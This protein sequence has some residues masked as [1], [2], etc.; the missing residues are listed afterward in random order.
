MEEVFI[1]YARTDIA[2]TRRLHDALEERGRQA[3]VDWEGIP[4]IDQWLAKIRSAIDEADAFVFVISPD[5]VASEVCGIE[6][7]H[8]IR[9]HKRLIPVVYREVEASTVR[10]ELAELNYIFA[11]DVDAFDTACERLITALDTDLKWVQAHTR[12]LVR[13]AEWDRAQRDASYTLRGRD[14]DDF[15]EW[16]AQSPDKEPKPTARLCRKF[17][18]EAI[19]AMVSPS[20]L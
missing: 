10:P 8:A 5:S 17:V 19:C 12:R 16:L 9:Q 2:F 14:L 1:S 7:E 18:F 13:A 11:R 6:L 4:P 15:E 3:W 20:D